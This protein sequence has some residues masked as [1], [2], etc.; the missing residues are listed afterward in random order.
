MKLEKMIKDISLELIKG[1]LNID[2]KNIAHDSRKIAADY[3]FICIKGFKTDGHHYIQDA[4]DNGA[5]AILIEKE[6]DTFEQGITYIKVNDTRKAMS[7]LA[8]AFY[9][10]PLEDLKLIG[11]TG[12]NGKTTTTYLIKSVLDT[13][14]YKTGLIGT[15]QNLID[16]ETLP[17]TRTTPKSLDIYRLLDKM[18]NQNIDYVVM[19]VSS[20]AL[21]LKRVEGMNFTTAVFTNISQDHLD[22]H[23]TL[24]KYLEVKSKLFKQ[25]DKSGYSVVNLDDNKSDKIIKNNNGKLFTY[26]IDNPSDLRAKNVEVRPD[27]VSFQ[28]PDLQKKI[29]LNIAGL[30]NVYNALAAFGVGKVLGL[31]AESIKNGL[32]VINGVAG[33]FELIKEEQDFTVVVDYAHT[34]DGMENVLETV[35]DLTP[36]KT[37]VV[38][39]CGGDRDKG[40]RPLMGKVGVKYGD[41]C[42]ITSDNPRSEDPEMIINDI[43]QGIKEF[44]TTTKYTVITDRKKAIHYA[45]NLANNGDSIVIFGKGHETY[46]VFKDKTI[47]FDDREVARKAINNL[48]KKGEDANGANADRRD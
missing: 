7:S 47:H 15:I 14:G 5:K 21:D 12:T 34:P 20:H 45:I 30:F 48:V 44:S 43:E 4:I 35:Q 33:R 28:L 39:G 37:I 9:N 23:E 31:N 22:Y 41:Y 8:A 1:D 29:N 18:R 36:G 40:K 19:E 11:V 42:I 16:E 27:G 25:V 24:E 17:A 32:E 13:A 10:Y 26:S 2:I 6:P 3:L 38:F 46:Q